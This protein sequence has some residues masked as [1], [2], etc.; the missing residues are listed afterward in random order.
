MLVKKLMIKDYLGECYF[1]GLLDMSFPITDIRIPRN[2]F[3]RVAPTFPA[4]RNISM[5]VQ[6]KNSFVHSHMPEHLLA[7]TAGGDV[8][9]Y[10][11]ISFIRQ[12][13]VPVSLSRNT[14]FMLR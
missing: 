9:I 8:W 6:L 2:K 11:K 12:K 7:L 1:I 10:R 13:V 14:I 5:Y 4:L 3:I